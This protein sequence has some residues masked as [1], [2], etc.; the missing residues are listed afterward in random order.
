MF[1]YK[2]SQGLPFVFTFVLFYPI[3]ALSDPDQE[4]DQSQTGGVPLEDVQR[5]SNAISQ[6]K[7]YYIKPISNKELFDN[8]I[9]G[10]LNGLDPHSSYLNEEDF[11]EK[12]NNYFN[13]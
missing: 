5:F 2:M 11:N 13:T 9:R 8:A 1:K 7:K 6:I 12:Y 3:L 4:T 10:M